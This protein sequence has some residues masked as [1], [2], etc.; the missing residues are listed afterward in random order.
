[1]GMEVQLIRV[2]EGLLKAIQANPELI[3]AMVFDADAKPPAGFDAAQDLWDGSYLHFFLP[4]FEHLAEAAGD[5]PEDHDSSEAVLADPLYRAINGE[6]ELD[7]D[8]CYGPASVH[9]PEK[10]RA[11]VEAWAPDFSKDDRAEPARM[12]VS[13][14]LFYEGAAKAGKAVICGIA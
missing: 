14:F 9:T 5:D 12:D 3:D 4:C 10:V 2:D 11:L 1:M 13:L 6:G 7:Y 8:F